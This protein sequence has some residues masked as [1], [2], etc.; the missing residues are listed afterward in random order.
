MKRGSR[1]LVQPKSVRVNEAIEKA[2]GM[3]DESDSHAL[4]R[5][6]SDTVTAWWEEH[7]KK[8]LEAA[9]KEKDQELEDQIVK[10]EKKLDALKAK[11]KGGE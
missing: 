6:V 10:Q 1:R 11:R 9:A 3:K 8:E 5:A 2:L 7:F 4:D